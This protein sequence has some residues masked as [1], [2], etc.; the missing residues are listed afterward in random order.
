MEIKHFKMPAVQDKSHFELSCTDAELHGN[1]WERKHDTEVCESSEMQPLI[2]THS[3]GNGNKL[4]LKSVLELNATDSEL[5]K[6]EHKFRCKNKVKISSEMQP[7]ISERNNSRND[8]GLELE[9]DDEFS[10]TDSELYKKGQKFRSKNKAKIY[11]MQPLILERNEC[12]MMEDKNFKMTM[13]S[14]ILI[15]N[16]TKK[17]KDLEPR[18]R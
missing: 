12:K 3:V 7:L 1:D 13:N 9:N 15:L 5:Y 16:Y 18:T 14:A 4:Q 8:D 10:Y 11:E 17:N 6:R 2:D